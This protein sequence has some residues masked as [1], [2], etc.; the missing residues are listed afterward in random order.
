MGKRGMAREEFLAKQAQRKREAYAAKKKGAATR[1][2]RRKKDMVH[3]S[4]PSFVENQEE[5]DS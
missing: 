1:S 4:L 2:Y 3:Q 5:V